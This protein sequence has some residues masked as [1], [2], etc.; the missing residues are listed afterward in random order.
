MTAALRNE[1]TSLTWREK[2]SDRDDSTYGLQKKGTNSLQEPGRLRARK[3]NTQ[4][5]DQLPGPAQGWTALEG[6]G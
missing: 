4:P 5:S 2:L 3:V 6:R 1:C